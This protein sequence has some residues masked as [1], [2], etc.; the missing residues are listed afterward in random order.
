MNNR[1][2]VLKLLRSADETNFTLA[3]ELAKG[4]PDLNLQKIL[5]EYQELYECLVKK[6]EIDNIGARHIQ[7]LT[8]LDL[9]T[10][11]KKTVSLPKNWEH[12]TQL[13]YLY[14]KLRT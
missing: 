6:V 3:L 10:V 4:M 13:K 7:I 5:K 14:Q 9:G 12:L 2:K 1:E 11:T 8:N